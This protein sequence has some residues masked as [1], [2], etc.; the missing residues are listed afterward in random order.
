MAY[1]TEYRFKFK[2]QPLESP[3]HRACFVI[4]FNNL[5]ASNTLKVSVCMFER[6]G[7]HHALIASAEEIRDA[8]L[9]LKELIP[10]PVVVENPEDCNIRLDFDFVKATKI[11][12]K[13]A[14]TFSRYF[15]ESSCSVGT[16]ATTIDAHTIMRRTLDY[17]KEN[18]DIPFIEVFQ[19]MH[20]NSYYPGG[21][22]MISNY[23]KEYPTAIISA[24]TFANRI[25]DSSINLLHGGF[26]ALFSGFA[27][28]IKNT[29][30]E[31]LSSL[32]LIERV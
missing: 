8:F 12:I 19:L 23:P 25:A 31:Y 26:G 11:Q 2:G 15:Y 27:H 16:R 10:E 20:Y 6:K 7:N 4:L 13:F 18:K 32:H 9:H 21:H 28:N 1:H 5:K 22:S 24:A 29:E 3:E 14:L 30:K 17:I